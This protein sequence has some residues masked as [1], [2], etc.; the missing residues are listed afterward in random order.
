MGKG[1]SAGKTSAV[2]R[3]GPLA[4]TIP[5]PFKEV[6]K[7]S[8]RA[9]IPAHLFKRS[10]VHSFGALG[11][12]LAWVV[13]TWLLAVQASGALPS[14]LSP[15]VWFAYWM[16]QGINCTA[17]WVLAHE[18]GHGG[19]VDSRV[20]ND[21]VGFVLHS[22]LLTPYFSW[23]ITHA[24]H[25]HYTNHMTNG[26]TWVPSTASPDKASVKF[27][28]TPL[29]TLRR[30]VVVFFLGWYTYLATNATGAKQN[31][32]Q[33]HFSPSS[34]SLFKPKDGNLVRASNLGMVLCAAVLAACVNKWGFMAVLFNYLVPQTVCNFYLCAIT[35]MQHTHESVPH[36]NSEEWTW[37]RGALSTIDRS[38]GPH[39]D[40]RLHHI[41]DSH[42]VH[43][44]FSDMPFY[45]AKAATPYVKEHL[46]TYYKSHFGTKVLGSEYLGYWKDFYTS[47]QNAVTVGVGEDGFMW[48][49]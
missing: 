26:E 15:L 40:W 22:G 25:H 33:S 45:G 48:F 16:Y 44:V 43:H 21:L 5:E 9:C 14:V 6:T 28:K 47:M 23:A 41:V 29:G 13:G 35:F 12:D 18:C 17:L 24:K 32:G 27:A 36:F 38:M 39:V 49:N 4:A 34:R 19:F 7:G 3:L 1:G 42:V 20:V 11:M 8:L 46:G 30:I 10:Y 37:L 31:L 2:E